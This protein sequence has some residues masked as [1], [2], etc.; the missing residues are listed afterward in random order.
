MPFAGPI[1]GQCPVFVPLLGVIHG[2]LLL[3]LVF[4]SLC[5]AERGRLARP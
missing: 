4:A 5:L 1:H 2:L 3:P